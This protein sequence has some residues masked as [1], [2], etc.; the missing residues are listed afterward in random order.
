MDEKGIVTIKPEFDLSNAEKAV[1]DLTKKVERAQAR[2]GA[3][4]REILRVEKDIE[5]I[6]QKKEEE[7]KLDDK[8]TKRLEAQTKRLEDLNEKQ[9]K[10]VEIVKTLNV[11]LEQ[12]KKYYDDLKSAEIPVYNSS[13]TQSQEAIEDAKEL[14]AAQEEVTAEM[15]EQRKIQAEQREQIRQEANDII[16]NVNLEKQEANIQREIARAREES[17][18]IIVGEGIDYESINARLNR[19]KEAVAAQRVEEEHLTKT[20]EQ[21]NA[22]IEAKKATLNDLI[23]GGASEGQIREKANE[24]AT[25]EE[26]ANNT[27]MALDRVRTIIQEVQQEYYNIAQYPMNIDA[28][29]FDKA[30]DD[31]KQLDAVLKNI[32]GTADEI[33]FPQLELSVDDTKLQS[34]IDKYNTLASQYKTQSALVSRLRAQVEELHRKE[35]EER[36]EGAVSEKTKSDLREYTAKLAEAETKLTSLTHKTQ[37]AR[38]AVTDY[39]TELDRSQSVAGK[40]SDYIQGQVSKIG[41]SFE[42]ITTRLKNM[43]F[44]FVVMRTLYAAFNKVKEIMSAIISENS[45]LGNSIN[46]LKSNLL[47]AFYP[48]LNLMAQGLERLVNWLIKATQYVSAFIHAITGAN[49]QDSIEGAK[50]LYDAMNADKSAQAEKKAIDAKIKQK[51]REIK[52]LEKQAKAIK[53]EYDAERLAINRKKDALDDEIKA[54]NR[55]IDALRKQE[56]AEKKAVQALKDSIQEQIEALNQRKK[57]REDEINAQKKALDAEMRAIDKEI[58]ALQKQKE[59]KQQEAQADEKSLAGF[60]TL[61]I[62]QGIDEENPEVKAIDEQIEALEE[63]KDILQETKD[64]IPTGSDDPLIAQIEAEIEAL[65]KQKE[66]IKDVDYSPL[67]E[68]QQAAIQGL[69]DQKE[70]LNE[71]LEKLQDKYDF[72]IDGIDEARE[73]IQEAIDKLQEE[74]AEIEAVRNEATKPQSFNVSFSGLDEAKKKLEDFMDKWGLLVDLIAGAITLVGVLAGSPALIISGLT[75]L[76]ADLTRI[77]N[78]IKGKFK[79]VLDIIFKDLLPSAWKK[80][81]DWLYE[82]GQKLEAKVTEINERL[83][84]AWDRFVKWLKEGVKSLGEALSNA[85]HNFWDSFNQGLDGLADGTKRVINTIIGLLEKAINWLVDKLPDW[86]VKGIEGVFHVDI[87]HVTLPRLEVAPLAKGAVLPGGKPFLAMLGDQPA[88]QTNIETPEKLLRQIVRDELNGINLNPNVDI[89]FD[90]NLSQLARILQPYIE[91]ANKR[92]SAFA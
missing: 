43:L 87:S 66:A 67:I 56:S 50:K 27:R 58:K 35:A 89:H 77:W 18:N 42:R 70:Y 47:V 74:K 82:I 29:G 14:K 8:Q 2:L 37:N 55:T 36:A 73:K 1:N 25:L 84:V 61:Q 34:L 83:N 79:L 92:A 11:E 80:F 86:A 12:A 39:A 26:E 62:L 5:S 6:N 53:K 91:V 60:D 21:Q 17:R 15:L 85:W 59:I 69:Q 16:E 52:A 54:V 22:V 38:Q 3:T 28:E 33:S 51:Q 13:G 44:R 4:E 41:N 78:K 72:K 46:Q 63:K 88:G 30:K 24:I 49:I 20:L 40:V 64:E 48:V 32:K 81:T 57:V 65:K 23:R 19:Y 10:Q 7:G 68:Q 71:L 90:G 45:S 9:L 31:A 76:I 75:V